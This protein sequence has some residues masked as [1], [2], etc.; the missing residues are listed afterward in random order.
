MEKRQSFFLAVLSATLAFSPLAESASAKKKTASENPLPNA[1]A[2]YACAYDVTAPDKNCTPIT[3]ADAPRNESEKI[4]PAS[5]SK[6]M[7]AHLVLR[8][9]QAN[10][11]KLSDPFVM[12]TKEDVVIGFTGERDGKKVEGGRC[13]LA[14]TGKTLS[15]EETVL[16]LTVYSANNVAVAAARVISPDGS[17]E[18]FAELMNNTA[19]EMGL[20]DTVFKT[21]S[22]MPATGQSTTAKDMGTLVHAIA[23][24]YGEE[25]FSRLFGQKSAVIAGEIVKSHLFLLSH[26][27]APIEGGKTGW[28]TSSGSSVAGLARRGNIAIAFAT[29]GSPNYEKRDS[30]TS[31]MLKKIF[32]HLG[33]ESNSRNIKLAAKNKDN[34]YTP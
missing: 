31:N 6:M 30:F 1:R 8:H 12:P 7:T 10:N 33:I 28:T 23:K 17:Q 3:L 25:K 11:K 4:E 20:S 15:Y 26:K 32:S 24:T 5:L 34:S 16:A 18:K 9:M 29:L 22:G 13:L 19:T 21:A 27:D 14:V 2:F